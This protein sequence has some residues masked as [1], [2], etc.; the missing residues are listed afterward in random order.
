[1]ETYAS[2]HDL[3]PAE[4]AA[5]LLALAVGD[6]GPRP[7]EESDAGRPVREASVAGAGD[8]PR[9][10]THP[11]G[12]GAGAPEPEEQVQTTFHAERPVGPRGE[13][14]PRTNGP[15]R[16]RAARRAIGVRYR[17]GVGH[18][19]GVRPEAIVGAITG[20]GGLRGADIGKIDIFGRFSLVEI[21]AD[22]DPEMA[23]RIGAARVAG[24]PLRFQVDEGPRTT[25]TRPGAPATSRPERKPRHRPR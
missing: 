2:A 11:S 3:E 6:E 17:L 12:T 18:E 19:H 22:V 24:R 9:S 1:V 13:H 15:E 23:R 16:A 14:P 25:K 10:A 4:L 7:R 8:G 20:E 5:V 21:T